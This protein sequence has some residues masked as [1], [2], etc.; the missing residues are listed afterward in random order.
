MSKKE[1]IFIILTIVG[2]IAL[3]TW[4]TIRMSGY[5]LSAKAN[6][7]VASDTPEFVIKPWTKN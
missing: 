6:A 2:A 4:Q 3:Y 7:P 1:V 5:M